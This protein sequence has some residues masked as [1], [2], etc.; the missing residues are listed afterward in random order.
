MTEIKFLLGTRCQPCL[1]YSSII[2]V[3]RVPRLQPLMSIGALDRCLISQTREILRRWHFLTSSFQFGFSSRPGSEPQ[4]LSIPSEDVQCQSHKRNQ[5]A[6]LQQKTF[7]CE[8]EMLISV[9][10][11]CNVKTK[12]IYN[13]TFKYI[14][15][16]ARCQPCL[17]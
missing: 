2:I 14:N 8:N 6:N 4:T 13:I 10:L 17:K 5:I 12:N 3:R 9:R 15:N 11:Y 1:K 16:C 7:F